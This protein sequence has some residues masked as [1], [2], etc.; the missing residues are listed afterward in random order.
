LGFERKA[1][2]G[3]GFPPLRELAQQAQERRRLIA[4]ADTV[5]LRQVLYRY[6]ERQFGRDEAQDAESQG[7]IA[8]G[9]YDQLLEATTTRAPSGEGK[10]E[11]LHPE[12]LAMQ[13]GLFGGAELVQRGGKGKA[14]GKGRGRRRSRRCR[15]WW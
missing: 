10:R 1:G 2:E 15:R 7:G 3:D 5:L 4:V 9:S 14:K 8:F 12:L 13:G 6:L 11:E